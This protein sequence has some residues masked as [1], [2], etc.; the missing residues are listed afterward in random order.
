M[1]GMSPRRSATRNAS[2]SF[3]TCFFQLAV[4]TD[5]LTYHSPSRKKAPGTAGGS[6]LVRR[7]APRSGASRFSGSSDMRG[8]L[9]GGRR[10]EM[11]VDALVVIRHAL[12]REAPLELGA[13]RRAVHPVHVADR[14][15]E[16]LRR[17][18][19]E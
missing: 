3:R 15:D 9:D 19:D 12:D 1:P 14:G 13:T 4:T 11:P 7:C 6:R 16:L 8:L 10:R 5:A 2:L 17:G 18:P